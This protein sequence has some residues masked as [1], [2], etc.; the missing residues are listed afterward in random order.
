MPRATPRF[1][2]MTAVY[3]SG[4][5]FANESALFAA[6][7]SAVYECLDMRDCDVVGFSYGAQKA[8]RYALQSTRPIRRLCLLSPAFFH[9]MPTRR[10][11]AEIRLFAANPTRYLRAF[12][13]QALGGDTDASAAQKELVLPYF[14]L[15]A[16]ESI[17]LDTLEGDLRILL[18]YTFCADEL[19][20]IRARGIEIEV[21]LGEKDRIVS[22]TEARDFFAP[23]TTRIFWVQ[24]AGHLLLL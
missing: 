23:L 19:T 6:P 11:E 21:F 3:F 5:G 22:A 10:K 13:Q 2:N 12:L 20:Q 14:C 8:V 16:P 9:T 24:G 1:R 4:F 17:Q 15:A 7:P 18:F